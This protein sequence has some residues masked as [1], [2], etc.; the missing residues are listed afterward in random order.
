MVRQM[1]DPRARC[2]VPPNFPSLTSARPV[3]I[4][5]VLVEV[6]T[7]QLRLCLLMGKAT[8]LSGRFDYVPAIVEGPH[9]VFANRSHAHMSF[10]DAALVVIHVGPFG[11]AE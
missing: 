5:V 7:L 3:S 4:L 2:C 10:S 11:I 9:Q 8:R 6:A 1:A